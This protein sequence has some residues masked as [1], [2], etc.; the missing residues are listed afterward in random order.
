MF[1]CR[2]RSSR[3]NGRTR[4]RRLPVAPGRIET[5]HGR[6]EAAAVDLV[7]QEAQFGI[8]GRFGPKTSEAIR[9]YQ[10]AAKLPVTGCP[11]C[12]RYCGQV[13]CPS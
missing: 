8:D 3:V 10:R 13:R 2:H 11:F 5:A 12:E 9:A 1:K 4:R 6:H 7:A